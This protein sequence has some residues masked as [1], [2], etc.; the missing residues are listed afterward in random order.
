[1]TAVVRVAQIAT[2]SHR[3]LPTA[4][5]IAVMVATISVLMAAHAAEVLV[6]SLAYATIGA[7]PA[8]VD[9]A[10]FAFVNYTTLGYGDVVPV[11]RWRLIG[12]ITAMNGM[13][14]FGWST[15]VIFEVLRRTMSRGSADV[16][17]ARLRKH[18]LNRGRLA[19]SRSAPWPIRTRSQRTS[20]TVMPGSNTVASPLRIEAQAQRIA[21]VVADRALGL[22]GR[23]RPERQELGDDRRRRSA[24]ARPPD[25]RRSLP[26]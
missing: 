25:A 6:W 5:M 7:A 13:L 20:H 1:M 15:A 22:P 16:A 18:E 26:R 17:V 12:P 9:L 8:G 24:R 10:Y 11:E 4:H 14:V 23:E 19:T 21:I 3:L 2:V